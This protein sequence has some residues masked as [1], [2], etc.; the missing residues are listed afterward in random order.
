MTKLGAEKWHC[1]AALFAA[2]SLLAPTAA[3]RADDSDTKPLAQR[4]ALMARSRALS[5]PVPAPQPQ[6]A[7]GPLL[8]PDG[9]VG[10]IGTDDD[11][12]RPVG[13]RP[14]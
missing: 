9:A 11:S 3:A 4:P 6:A 2:A 5:P 8:R 1:L 13:P 12:V 7:P 10:R 14:R